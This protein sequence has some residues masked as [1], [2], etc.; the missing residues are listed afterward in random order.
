M[1][2][3]L[4]LL[5]IPICSSAQIFTEN[6]EAGIP[7]TWTT[8]GDGTWTTATEAWE[9]VL[10]ES[11]VAIYDDDAGGDES[12]VSNA[13]LISPV[14]DL[15]NVSNATLAFDY[16]NYIFFEDSSLTVEVF[17]GTTWQQV[18]MA[19]GDNY[20]EDTYLPLNT[21]IDISMYANAL[22]KVR[23]V[24]NDA[25]DWSFGAAVDNVVIDGTLGLRNNEP[26]TAVSV[27]PNPVI[28]TFKLNATE[29]FSDIG[30]IELTDATGKSF[31]IKQV[32]GSFDISSLSS[33]IYFAKISSGQ[34]TK[35]V[36]VVKQ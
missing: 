2:K 10:F 26:R 35:I 25:G 29:L 16:G 12:L 13:Q 14:I 27:Y 28:D 19:I 33:G 15:S 20:D 21:S 18:F 31:A 30:Q 32:N 4:L 3:I 22:F 36:K 5:L 9:D 1:K 7:A 17:D 8:A 6:F 11:T 23:F 34:N 24:Y